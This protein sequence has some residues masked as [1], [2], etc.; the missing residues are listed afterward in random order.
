MHKSKLQLLLAD[1]CAVRLI[2]HIYNAHV[3]PQHFLH[4]S[5]MGAT[6][7]LHELSIVYPKFG[8][9]FTE[10]MFN[11][12]KPNESYCRALMEAVKL[13]ENKDSLEFFGIFSQAQNLLDLIENNIEELS[14]YLAK[15]EC[16]SNVFGQ[17]RAF[18]SEDD[19][20]TKRLSLE[21][22]QARKTLEDLESQ[23]EALMTKHHK[24]G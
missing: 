10:S 23:A 14:G 13:P 21:I 8:F 7:T 5:E 2:T 11:V 20:E 22:D 12:T 6:S 18:T 24:V 4:F 3:N 9:P 15:A 19:K 1:L 16:K 17:T